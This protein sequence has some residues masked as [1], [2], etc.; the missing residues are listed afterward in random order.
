MVV[1][2]VEGFSAGDTMVVVVADL[3]VICVRGK[4]LSRGTMEVRREL[5]R[6]EEVTGVVRAAG[7]ISLSIIKG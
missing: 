5:C 2:R 4:S 7:Q 1:C 3:C 6:G